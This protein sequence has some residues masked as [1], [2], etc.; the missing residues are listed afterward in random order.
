MRNGFEGIV[1]DG[2][3]AGAVAVGEDTRGTGGVAD[4]GG[5]TLVG[6]STSGE[7]TGGRGRQGDTRNGRFTGGKTREANDGR[8]D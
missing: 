8:V 2:K 3:E 6:G 4:E 1:T 7:T 5:L